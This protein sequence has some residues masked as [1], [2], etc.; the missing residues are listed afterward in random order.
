MSNQK[1]ENPHQC[2]L[3][4][5]VL[6]RVECSRL[7]PSIGVGNS[8][9]RSREG[10]GVVACADV[11]GSITELSIH[12]HSVDGSALV[13]GKYHAVS[14]MATHCTHQSIQLVAGFR[15]ISSS[16]ALDSSR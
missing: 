14:T 12:W 3:E 7:E 8:I 10:E 5:D 13:E 6:A 9:D 15:S 1:F 2:A 16:S 4:F 11:D